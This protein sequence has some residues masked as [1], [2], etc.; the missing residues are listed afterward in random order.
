AAMIAAR[1][2]ITNYELRITNEES[3][4]SSF[5]IRNS[6]FSGNDPRLRAY[7]STQTHSSVAKAAGVAGVGRANLRAVGVDAQF[8]MRPDALRAA[9]ESDLAAGLR[10]FFVV[11]T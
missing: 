6:S 3:A 10:P 8:A 11:A 9:I 2:R 5:V 7:C 4:D 1:D